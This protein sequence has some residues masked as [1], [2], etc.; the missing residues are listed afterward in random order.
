MQNFYRSFIIAIVVLLS[1]HSLRAQIVS[2][3]G[4]LKEQ[5]IEAGLQ[6]SGAFGSKVACPADYFYHNNAN[7]G[8][9]LGFISD[10]GKDGWT[11]GS[12]AYI[13]DYFLPGTPYEGFSVQIDGTRYLNSGSAMTQDITGSITGF[14]TTDTSQ[15]VEWIGTINGLRVRQVATVETGK[16]FIL[17]RIYLNNTTSSAINNI[18]YSREVDP[19]NEVTEGGQ[20]DTKNIIEQQNPNVTSTALISAN[21]LDFGS[22]LGLGSRDCRARVAIPNSWPNANGAD[23]WNGSGMM[24]T[25]VGNVTGDNAMSLAFNVGSL[26]AGD[27]TSLAY[28]YVLNAADLP[29]A[30]DETDPLFNVKANT[31]GSGSSVNVCAGQADQISIANGGGFTWTWSPSTGLDRT[32][33]PTVNAV[34]TGPMTYTAAGTNSCGTNRSITVT[35]N[36]TITTAPDAAGT[37]SGPASVVPGLNASFSVAAIN[38][39]STYQWALPAGATFVSGYNTN[40]IVVNFGPSVADGSVSVFGQNGC[41]MGDPSSLSVALSGLTAPVPASGIGNP[42]SN[43]NPEIT[44]TAIPG[45][46]VTLYDG[47]T[48]IGSATADASGNYSITPTSALSVGTHTLTVKA[49]DGS[50]NTS[51]ASAALSLR[52]VAAP[53]QPPAPVLAS[54]ANPVNNNE[55]P[56]TGTATAGTTVTI[57]VDGVVAGTTTADGS[58][59]WSY[60]PASPIADGPHDITITAT[61]GSGNASAASPA[62]SLTVDTTPPSQASVPALVSGTSPLNIN[63]PPFSGTADPGSTVTVYVDGIVIGTTMADGSGNWTYT[64][65]GPIADGIH[66]VTVTATDAAGNVGSVSPSMSLT[67]DTTPPA[68]ASIPALA[69]GASPVNNNEPPLKGT[70][71]AGSTVTIY[72]DGV[73]AGT[74]TADGSGN[75]AYTPSDPMTDGGHAITVT[76]TDAAGNAGAASPALSLTVDTASPAQASVPVLAA[77][78]SPVNIN[79]PPLKGT[80]EAGSTVTVAVDGVVIGTTTADGSGNWTYTPADPITDGEHTVTVTATDA[81][82]NAGPAS[83]GLDFN[84]DTRAPST[85]SS[86][87]L[88]DGNNGNTNNPAPTIS[89]TA[90]AGSTVTVYQDGVAVGTT[91]ADGAGNWTYTFSPALADNNYAISITA[92]DAAG[93]TS[94]TSGVQRLNIDTQTPSSPSAPVLS[95]DRNGKTNNNTPALSGTAEPGSTVTVYDN[96]VAAGTAVAGPDGNWTYTFQPALPDGMNGITTTAT[97]SAGNVSPSSA[98][99]DFVIDTQQPT[100]TITSANTSVNGAFQVTI[101]FSEAVPGFTSSGITLT[102]GSILKFVAV[103]ASEY[104]ATIMPLSENTVTVAVGADVVTDSAG[105]GNKVSNTFSVQAEFNAVVQEVYPNPARGSINIQFSGVVPANGKVMLVNLLGQTVLTEQLNFQGNT[106]LTMN[107]SGIAEGMYVL[108]V[109]AKNYTYKTKVRIIR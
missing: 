43:K 52:I 10:V 57:Y 22:Y 42:T 27:S 18:Y 53:P 54:G 26:A 81:A 87:S 79:E 94:G 97:D 45:A 106:T 16:S 107:T 36:P 59:N 4:F 62:L 49:T 95:G 83:T 86:P 3:N 33:G 28:A 100:A 80:A 74:T 69:A 40:S 51:A 65:S 66:T 71:E 50:G 35:L 64:P 46:T 85:P 1:V 92:T 90:E 61:D 20:Y 39:A 6:P 89:G 29:P 25:T 58:G 56:L 105:N 102:D 63:E 19:D 68:Q 91:T 7:F 34:L 55:P 84:V 67:V 12:P 48:P 76:A 104:T 98:G 47:S 11:V 72:I 17:V 2:G 14:S 99:L 44:G 77:G 82:G 103:S 8:G 13:G 93:N 24:K 5:Y 88:E 38:G 21:G 75:W 41:G 23:I 96:G 108:V 78:T 101:T 73:A 60:T 31:Y 70:A 15:S 37:I 30:M 32:T 9:K 109:S